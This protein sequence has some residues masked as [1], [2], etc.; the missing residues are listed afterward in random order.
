[1]AER[2]RALHAGRGR[3]HHSAGTFEGVDVLTSHPQ[4]GRGGLRLRPQRRRGFLST[5]GSPKSTAKWLA[6]PHS[7]ISA[8][9]CDSGVRRELSVRRRRLPRPGHWQGLDPP[10]SRRSR[11]RGLW[12]LQTSAF[13]KNRASLTLHHQAVF[14]TPRSPRTHRPAPRCLVRH[15]LHRTQNRL[16]R[17]LMHTDAS[18]SSTGS[19]LHYYDSLT[20]FFPARYS[21]LPG[22]PFPGDPNATKS[23]PASAQTSAP[24]TMSRAPPSTT[25]PSPRKQPGS[26]SPQLQSSPRPTASTVHTGQ[27]C[28]ASPT[29]SA[30]SCTPP[31]TAPP[32]FTS[33]RIIV[34]GASNSAVQSPSNSP[35]TP[36]SPSPP[37]PDPRHHPT[38]PRPRH[39][40]R[41]TTTGLDHLLIGPLLKTN[42]PTPSC[43]PPATAQP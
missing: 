22:M 20:L 12:T 37:A 11:R 17:T 33:Q 36:T 29:T 15:R 38:S 2:V 5:A 30:P 41:S 8:R 4:T 3:R 26:P 42:T 16:T 23:S 34:V 24:T 21:S 31:N 18:D 25:A 10:A 19:W 7:P 39:P 27:T 40:L 9:E 1:M 43:S 28:P 14:H 35:S 6:G 32:P 13:P